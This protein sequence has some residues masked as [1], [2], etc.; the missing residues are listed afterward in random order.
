MKKTVVFFCMLVVIG[1]ASNSCISGIVLE[2]EE[3]P[4]PPPPEDEK[5][6]YSLRIALDNM[7]G[8]VPLAMSW[9]NFRRVG[10]LLEDDKDSVIYTNKEINIPNTSG[11]AAVIIRDSVI[12]ESASG[13][14]RAYAPFIGTLT[15]TTLTGT[16][17]ATQQQTVNSS[18]TMDNALINNLKLVANTATFNFD[19]G[20]CQLNL[21]NL[22]SVIQ[23]TIEDTASLLPDRSIQSIK[24]YIAKNN[25][26][27]T[28]ISRLTLA[29]T[30]SIDLKSTNSAVQFQNPEYV[31][32]ATATS[33]SDTQLSGK[34]VFYFIVN[35]FTL[36][37]DE[38]CAVTI[39]TDMDDVI[40]I[41]FEI[42][43]VRNTIHYLQAFISEENTLIELPSEQYSDIYSNCYIISKKGK[44]KI[45]ADKTINNGRVLSGTDVDWLWASKEGGGK[46]TIS[47]LI[48]PSNLIFD[49][50]SIT[51]Q[52]G[53][54]DPF[55][56]MNNGNVILALKNENDEIEWTWH[57]WITDD[58][59][60]YQHEN[61]LVLLDRNIGALSARMSNTPID[62]YGFVYQWGRKDPFFGGNG[63]SNETVT[64]AMSI[65]R[66]NTIVNN[67]FFNDW[68]T[69]SNVV[70][71]ATF[72][73]QNPMTF[74]CNN[75]LPAPNDGQA[76]WLSG[77]YDPNRWLENEK[78]ENDP[79]PNGY[80]VPSQTE[81]RILH[82][83]AAGDPLIMY[84]RNEGNRRW[85]YYFYSGS[86]ITEWPAA[87]M[88]Q[89]RNSYRGNTGAQLVYSGTASTKGECYYWT[90][91]PVVLS[92]NSILT[93]GSH[94][95]Y[96]SGNILHH[97]DSF[98]DN[99]D[100][101]PI[102]CVKE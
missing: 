57:I 60:D 82:N 37:S 11:N 54:D 74:I 40:Y 58:L 65:A 67:D 61:E 7:N 19:E 17:N 32:N 88:R 52:V 30:Y 78:T 96:T 73:N 44:Y 101:Y 85:D 43:T 39:E 89:G 5:N 69:P 93:G 79:C 68:P 92:N 48:N 31:I 21:R 55:S 33:N 45:P 59:M 34:P 83:A 10:F 102:R 4:T 72:A 2:D 15:G 76:D 9:A 1:I 91:S 6:S 49:G 70:R 99:A 3:I 87:G 13:I 16:L 98:G 46:F 42:N 90:S 56:T 63:L 36:N 8:T 77:F 71:T 94:R 81:M 22:F 20:T 97:E 66:A 53:D 26:V 50:S 86:V 27:K 28:P 18:K 62:N 29:G 12:T 38:T 24:L 41:P 75:T 51:F 23:L 47:E 25:D 100:A 84:F 14:G 95:I 80:R 64:N 35:P